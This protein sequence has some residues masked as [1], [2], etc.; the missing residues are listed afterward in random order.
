M[1]WFSSGGTKSVVHIDSYDNI[2][3]VVRGRKHVTLVD[4]KYQEKVCDF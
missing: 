4:E 2:L 3:C 1:M